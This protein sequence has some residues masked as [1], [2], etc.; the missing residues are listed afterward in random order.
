M[1][2]KSFALFVLI[3]LPGVWGCMDNR[4]T[5]A[6]EPEELYNTSGITR[7]SLFDEEGLAPVTYSDQAFLRVGF[8]WDAEESCRLEGRLLGLSGRWSDWKPIQTRWSEGVARTGHLDAQGLAVGFQLR[9]SAGPEP[10]HLV[11]EAIEGIGEPI[12]PPAADG[13]YRDIKQALAPASLVNPRSAWG[14]RSPACNPGSHS[15][16]K[17]TVHHTATPLPDS[18]SPEARVRQIQNYHIDSRGWCDIGYH[19]LVDWNGEMWQGRY[20]TVLGAHVAN[21]NTSNVGISFMGTYSSTPASGAQLDACAGLLDWLHDNYGIPMNR[22]YIKGHREYGGTSCPGD[23]LYSQLDDLVARANGNPGQDPGGDPGSDPSVGSLLG[24]VFEDQGVGTA[25]MSKR[26]PGATVQISGAGSATARDGDAYW[27]FSLPPGTYTVTASAD[28]HQAASRTCSV[29]AGAESWCSVGLFP[30]GSG[31]DPDPGSDQDPG[32]DPGNDPV[33]DPA[34]DP[35]QTG[36]LFGYVVELADPL[37]ADLSDNPPVGDAE[38]QSDC[39]ASTLSDSS[40]Y[41]ELEVQAGTRILTAEASGYDY[42][43]AVCTVSEGGATECFVP[44]VPPGQADPL[45]PDPFD[46]NAGS[47]DPY[48]TGGCSTAGRAPDFAP[49][50][51]L[52][53]LLLIRRRN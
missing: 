26:L 53:W 9:I 3:G 22:S 28:G 50:V 39:G 6:L 16:A 15:P 48:L 29:Q 44:V 17:V 37:D 21:N 2:L 38:I 46:P 31:S 32:Q 30:D 1:K 11:A 40:G 35:G 52:G 25:D 12:V 51:L 41:F 19:Y 49:L 42:A 47:E 7:G 5:G 23:R 14:A 24:V 27:S 43:S 20:E 18:I 45:D 8:M 36:L 34:Q 4:P 10:T 33:Q 13:R